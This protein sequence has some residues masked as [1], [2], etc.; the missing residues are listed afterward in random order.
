MH[1]TYK[2]LTATNNNNNKYLGRTNPR[3]GTH[4][5][6]ANAFS[7]SGNP[8]SGSKVGG[9]KA[10]RIRGQARETAA[11]PLTK[12]SVDPA[13]TATTATAGAASPSA[14]LLLL[15]LRLG[16]RLPVSLKKKWDFS[17]STALVC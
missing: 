3:A 6:D 10:V 12:T 1:G 2:Y 14:P 5:A 15:L 8:S 16:L 7:A 11:A 17:S 4:S 13:G 9:H